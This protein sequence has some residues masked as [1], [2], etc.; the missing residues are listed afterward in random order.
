MK[1]DPQHEA[2]LEEAAD[3]FLRLGE[4]PEDLK[5]RKRFYGWLS[6]SAENLRAWE[7]TCATWKLMGS[8]P[9]IHEDLWRGKAQP[10]SNVM[11]LTHQPPRRH[12]IRQIAILTAAVA[13][14]AAFVWI[15]IP[16]DILRLEADYRTAIAELQEIRLDDGSIVTLGAQSAMAVDMT[17]SRRHVR[18][19]AGE[20]FFEVQPDTL[21]PFVVAAGNVDA[22]V[23]G[24][25]FNVRLETDATRIDLAEGS[26]R[27]SVPGD[28]VLAPGDSVTVL[29]GT[30]KIVRDHVPVEDMASWRDGRMFVNDVSIT[31]V[32]ERIQRYHPAW[33]KLADGS[34][35]SQK[36]TGLYDLTD[37]DRALRALVQPYGGKVR[38]VSPWVAILT[39]W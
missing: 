37:P 18:L 3:W 22:T 26:L 23:L 15:A 17:G 7:K 36:V 11:P 14:I 35:G 6:H 25:S 39:R 27:V 34:L 29:H 2:R 19:L 13:A 30:G 32:V 31:A 5:L 20:A 10:A 9:P 33:I 28:S 38:Q 4:A 21:R 8:V 24:T 1:S 16:E 12:S